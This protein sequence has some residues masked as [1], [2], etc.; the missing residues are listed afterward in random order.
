M[1]TAYIYKGIRSPFGRY[2]GSISRLRPDDMAAQLVDH[3]TAGVD[4][5]KID[6]LVFGCSNQAGEDS[7]NIS[8]N[9][10]L[11]SQLPQSIPAI[12]LN[13]LCASG[14]AAVTH[15]MRAIQ[16][17]EQSLMVAGGVESMSRA[18]FVMGKADGPFGRNQTLYDTTLGNRFANKVIAEKYGTHSMAETG[19][20]LAKEVGI[21]RD[22]ADDYAYR[23]QQLYAKALADGFYQDEIMAVEVPPAHRKAAAESVNTDEHPR[24]QTAREKLTQLKTLFPGGVVTAGNAS[25]INDGS[26][27]LLLGNEGMQATAGTKPMVKVLG[28]ASVGVEPRTMGLGPVKAIK[29]LLNRFS[30]NL[31]D[32]EV[33]EINEAFACQVL[34]CLKLLEIP[35]DDSRVNP[36]GGAIAIGHPLGAS[37]AR[38]ALTASRQLHRIQGQYA[39]VSLCVGLGQGE[40]VLLERV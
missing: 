17:G 23:S 19:D 3:I 20:E 34:G 5:A 14:L 25:G 16:T 33:I 38:L 26:A 29:N 40:A 30:L 6:E 22:E 1:E 10:V 12:T 18:P 24:P 37:G 8:R 27:A 35:Y 7:R 4:P 13:R 39:I 36:N 32:I 15:G 11:R 21:T 28:S 31:K 2:G 9:V